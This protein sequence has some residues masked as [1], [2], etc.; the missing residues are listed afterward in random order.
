VF[1][2]HLGKVQR[3]LNRIALGLVP[4]RVIILLLAVFALIA[5]ALAACSAGGPRGGRTTSPPQPTSAYKS[6]SASASKSPPIVRSNGPATANL[7]LTGA[8]GIAGPLRVGAIECGLPGLSGS[9]IV[10]LARPAAPGITLK[11]VLLPKAVLIVVGTG[12]GSDIKSRTFVGAGIVG[13]DAAAGANVKSLLIEAKQHASPGSVGSPSSIS[14]TVD[15]GDQAPGHST[16]TVHGQTASGLL[17]GTPLDPLKVI[18]TALPEGADVSVIGLTHAGST[19]VLVDVDV[20]VK[21]VT[22][23][24]SAKGRKAESYFSSTGTATASAAGVDIDRVVS[25]AG[26]SQSLHVVGSATCGK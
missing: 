6:A 21:S 13:F 22:V 16:M 10:L 8:A 9:S 15:C 11:I 26:T 2:R 19:A 18:C 23:T 12:S 25:A 24:I 3:V 1:T 17:S 20:R 14:G 4:V 7:V 5:G